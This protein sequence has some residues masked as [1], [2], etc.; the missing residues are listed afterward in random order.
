L[1]ELVN[2]FM[3]TGQEK[4]REEIIELARQFRDDESISDEHFKSATYYVRIFVSRIIYCNIY[5]LHY[6]CKHLEIR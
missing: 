3:K 2:E 1:D 6:S 4:R 5:S